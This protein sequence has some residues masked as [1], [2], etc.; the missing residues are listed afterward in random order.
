[1]AKSYA[2][3]RL[4]YETKK[5]FHRGHKRSWLACLAGLGLITSSPMWADSDTVDHYQRDVTAMDAD[6]TRN[7][8]QAIKNLIGSHKEA[9]ALDKHIYMIRYDGEV[10]KDLALQ[11]RIMKQERDNHREMVEAYLFNDPR[12]TEDQLAKFLT[13]LD[14]AGIDMNARGGEKYNPYM[15]K[16]CQV[17]YGDDFTNAWDVKQCMTGEERHGAD[18][19]VPAGMAGAFFSAILLS[20]TKEPWRE[21]PVRPDRQAYRRRRPEH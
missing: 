8:E 16:E 14:T 3:A 21:K 15:L 17:T 1:M 10:P 6:M 20:M 13:R 7:A 11:A 5:F 12:M 18:Q 9:E 19:M 4:S 2:V